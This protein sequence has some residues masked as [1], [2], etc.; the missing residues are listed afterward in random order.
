MN[1]TIWA[2]CLTCI[3]LILTESNA[4]ESATREE[5]NNRMLIW[6]NEVRT[7]LLLCQLPGQPQA[8]IMPNLTYDP[9]LADKAQNWANNCTSGHDKNEDRKTSNY[10]YVGQ[11]FAGS[12]YFQQ[13]FNLWAN[14]HTF[15]NYDGN[16]CQSGKMCG[17]YTQVVWAN[18]KYLGCAYQNCTGNPNFPWGNS[19]IC[20]YGEG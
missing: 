5:L 6:H 1:M 19:I 17:H 10:S 13:G 2:I 16:S 14:E 4:Q 20:N 12:Y 18:T 15:Y 7:K 9:E 11:N 8:K 3:I